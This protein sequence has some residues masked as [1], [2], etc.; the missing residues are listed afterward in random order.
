MMALPDYVS[1]PVHPKPYSPRQQFTAA[2]D[3]AL[4]LLFKCFVMNPLQ[5]ITAREVGTIYRHMALY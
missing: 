5:R 4:D 3:D 1:L 2:S